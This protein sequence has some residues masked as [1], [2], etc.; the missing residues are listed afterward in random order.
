MWED[1]PVLSIDDVR[2]RYYIRLHAVDKP[3]VLAQVAANF[4]AEGVSIESMVQQGRGEGQPVPIVFI[5]HDVE[6]GCGPV[7]L[8]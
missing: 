4:G 1:V 3:G 5:T 6:G 8:G 2:T 7:W